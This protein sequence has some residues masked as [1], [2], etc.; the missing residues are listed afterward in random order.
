MFDFLCSFF[1]CGY[2]P[3]GAGVCS[4]VILGRCVIVAILGL[5]K[6]CLLILTV[7]FL[8]VGSVI[9]TSSTFF[10]VSVRMCA[11]A[12]SGN[13][14]E[15]FLI[16]NAETVLTIFA[17]FDVPG[18][19]AL[20]CVL[21]LSETEL[22]MS[23]KCCSIFNPEISGK[24]FSLYHFENLYWTSRDCPNKVFLKVSGGLY[25]VINS[26]A[27]SGTRIGRPSGVLLVAKSLSMACCCPTSIGVGCVQSTGLLNSCWS[28]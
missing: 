24:L 16:A 2:A 28:S 23:S 3:G 26:T 12:G 21:Y 25:I 11:E 27:E 17:A 14:E 9:L 6:R 1:S 5:G 13:N 18:V 20:S 10:G 7:S 22:I 8:G 4:V 15:T 19:G